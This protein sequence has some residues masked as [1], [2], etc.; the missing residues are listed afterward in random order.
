M[1]ATIILIHFIIP[2]TIFLPLESGSMGTYYNNI[3]LPSSVLKN[4]S[5]NDSLPLFNKLDYEPP[6]FWATFLWQ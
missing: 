3:A 5:L 1:K 2:I 4:D 6:V